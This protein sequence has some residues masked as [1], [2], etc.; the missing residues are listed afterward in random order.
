[1]LR[2][3]RLVFVIALMARTAGYA[4]D[5]SRSLPESPATG[6][7]EL[8]QIKPGEGS[9]VTGGTFLVAKLRYK[10]DPFV[11]GKYFVMP[12]F[13]M[14]RPGASSSGNLPRTAFALEEPSGFVTISIPM[15]R[16]VHDEQLRRPLEL[17]FFL[18]KQ[19]D[20]RHSH[21]LAKTVLVQY[22]P[23]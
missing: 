5:A 23:E 17:R 1:M 18:N 19:D 10:V 15:S 22:V 21:I 20:S 4:Q 7:L 6:T 12:Q 3:L 11:K 13:A 2:R 14:V 9:R 16:I 8:V